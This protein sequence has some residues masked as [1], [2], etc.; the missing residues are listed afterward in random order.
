MQCREK[1]TL[2]IMSGTGRE[3]HYDRRNNPTTASCELK[4]TTE[5]NNSVVFVSV[6]HINSTACE[7]KLNNL[8]ID[9]KQFSANCNAEAA[10]GVRVDL[11]ERS[12]FS[13]EL[14]SLTESELNYIKL[15]IIGKVQWE[16]LYILLYTGLCCWYL[17]AI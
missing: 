2:A 7:H 3:V 8:F 13:I 16:A 10:G 9:G 1:D 15:Y 4:I 5:M 14:I 17:V 11:E 12:E 6:L